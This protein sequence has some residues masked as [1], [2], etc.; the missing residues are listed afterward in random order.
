MRCARFIDGLPRGVTVAA[1]ADGAQGSADAWDAAKCLKSEWIGETSR[2][3]PRR[4][5]A[6]PGCD[7]ADVAG[8]TS[9]EGEG[10][11][12][13]DLASHLDG[14]CKQLR[15]TVEATFGIHSGLLDRI[16][17][18]EWKSAQGAAITRV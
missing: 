12:G 2:W 16:Q 1:V 18:F 4:A 15:N 14:T 7:T 6:G 17:S 10:S 13:E 3:R 11:R 8:S 5:A 9:G